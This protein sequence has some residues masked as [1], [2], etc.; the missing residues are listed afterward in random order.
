MVHIFTRSQFRSTSPYASSRAVFQRAC[1]PQP[2]GLL[3]IEFQKN[4]VHNGLVSS[5]L[6]MPQG[7]FLVQHSE[8]FSSITGVTPPP[9]PSQESW[10]LSRCRSPLLWFLRRDLPP[11]LFKS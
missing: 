4:N 8:D 6:V 10:H 3:G 9:L 1:C 11:Y 7:S 5:W 2:W